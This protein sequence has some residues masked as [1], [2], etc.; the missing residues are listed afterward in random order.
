MIPCVLLLLLLLLLLL[1]FFG[2]F[3]F[4]FSVVAMA[5]ALFRKIF[6]LNFAQAIFL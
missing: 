1:C 2:M 6:D 4:I 3:V 5:A